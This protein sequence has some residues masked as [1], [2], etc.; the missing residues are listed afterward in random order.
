MNVLYH[1]PILPPAMPAAEAFSQEIAALQTQ[2]QGEIVY[3]NP[4]Q[5]SPVY[6]PR[7]LFG[8]SKIRQI[9][10]LE[11]GID[12][13]HFFNPDPFSYPILLAFRRPVVYSLS[14]GL[15][16]NLPNLS[17]FSRLAAV[18]VYDRDSYQ[19]LCDWGLTNVHL[20]RSG[21]DVNRFTHTALSLTG[22]IRLLVASAPWTEAQF[23]SKGVDAL[24]AAA[25]RIPRLQLT[26][27]WRGVFY[28]EMMARVKQAGLDER[29]QVINRQVDVNEIL[30]GMHGTVNLAMN[31]A[32]IKAYPHSLLDSLAAGKPVIV[33]RAIAMSQ[34]VEQSGCGLV[35]NEVTANG[36]ADG[37]IVAINEFVEKYDSLVAEA[38]LV[39]RRDFNQPQMIDS[40][41]K[42]YAAVVL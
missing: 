7:L 3:L 20:V 40:F 41:R 9:R 4:N 10:A 37:L 12:L 31:G 6:L 32:I 35:V 13:H 8:W 25:Q 28:A 18:T 38:M 39:G 23:Q 15:G 42:V 36:L 29:V 1:L 11:T 27:L 2:F 26:F 24:L 30:A 5:S 34:D 16:D 17:Y 14:S 21:I 19:K 22:D 33:S